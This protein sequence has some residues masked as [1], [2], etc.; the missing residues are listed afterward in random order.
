MIDLNKIIPYQTSTWP[1]YEELAVEENKTIAAFLEKIYEDGIFDEIGKLIKCDQFK[2][3]EKNKV[4]YCVGIGHIVLM[5]V[6]SAV[7]ILGAYA[8]GTKT[9]KVGH[10]FKN[11]IS[12]Y[13]PEKYK[14]VADE[15]YRAFRCGSVHAWFLFN[16]KIIGLRDD[17]KHLKEDNGLLHISLI[18]FF[19]DLKI[20]F[21]KYCEVIIKDNNAKDSLLKRYKVLRSLEGA[22]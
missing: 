14:G 16:G 22:I 7:D 18:D 10:R 19:D 1:T 13:F 12:S 6:C 21:Q 11:F 3:Q 2:R 17:S 5:A 9:N 15:I 8:T 4:F 20:G